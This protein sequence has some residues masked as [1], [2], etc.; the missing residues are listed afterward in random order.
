MTSP[1][2][3]KEES[4]NMLQITDEIHHEDSAS[5][6]NNTV[7]WKVFGHNIPRS[8]VVFITQMIII[9]LVI[10]SCIIN[11]SVQNG[12]PEMWVSFFGLAFGA[13]LPPPKLKRAKHITSSQ[14]SYPHPSAG[15]DPAE[16]TTV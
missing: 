13:M 16:I 11:L 9:T 10:I 14:R 6:T 12:N 2:E 5:N 8:E 1:H 15:I 4:V 7:T 3:D